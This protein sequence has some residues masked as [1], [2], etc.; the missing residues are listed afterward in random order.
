MDPIMVGHFCL[1]ILMEGESIFVF[2]KDDCTLLYRSIE[3]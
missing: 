3:L 1:P 2:M